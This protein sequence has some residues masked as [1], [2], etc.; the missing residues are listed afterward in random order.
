MLQLA[1]GPPLPPLEEEQRPFRHM[2]G[3]AHREKVPHA[4]PSPRPSVLHRPELQDSPAAQSRLVLQLAPGPPFPPLEGSGLK[5]TL[6]EDCK[7]RQLVACACTVA[8]AD[9]VTTSASPLEPLLPR[10]LSKSRAALFPSGAS[11]TLAS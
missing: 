3:L 6:A 5:R 4:A 8:G 7:P 1:P 2:S 10:M 11:L 9:M